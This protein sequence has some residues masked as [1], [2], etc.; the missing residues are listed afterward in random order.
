MTYKEVND[1]IL[2]T[3]SNMPTVNSVTNDS[4]NWNYNKNTAYPAV[5]AELQNVAVADGI[6]SYNYNFT[7]AMIGVESEADRVDNYS[8]MMQIL[9][10]GLEFINDNTDI[11]LNNSYNFLFASLKF[12]DVLDCATCTITIDAPID[13]DCEIQAYLQEGE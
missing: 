11:E 1:L 9:Y 6:A 7:A 3:F 12:M 2:S 5:A 8:R 13:V 4:A 10:E